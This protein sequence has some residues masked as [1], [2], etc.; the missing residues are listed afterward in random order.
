LLGTGS[1][2]VAPHGLF[3]FGSCNVAPHGLFDSGSCSLRAS[4]PCQGRKRA[5]MEEWN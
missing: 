4:W 5:M 3:V 2:N 1:C